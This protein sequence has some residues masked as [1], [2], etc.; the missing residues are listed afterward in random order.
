MHLRRGAAQR[1]WKEAFAK[2]LACLPSF[3]LLLSFRSKDRGKR[4]ASYWSAPAG[5]SSCALGLYSSFASAMAVAA[6]ASAPSVSAHSAGHGLAMPQLRIHPP[7]PSERRTTPDMADTLA[8]LSPWEKLLWRKQPYPDNYV[9]D[10]FLDQL[11]T[12]STSSCHLL[13]RD[14]HT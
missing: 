10:S 6:L 4:S 9:P 7:K 13:C 3:H 1:T 11:R 12:N 8:E 5:H 2:T 14:P